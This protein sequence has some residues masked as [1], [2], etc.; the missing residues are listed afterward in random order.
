M[1]AVFDGPVATVCGKD[2]LRIGLLRALAG[3]AICVFRGLFTGFLFCNLSLD[4]ECL[5]NVGKVEVVVEFCCGPDFRGIAIDEVRIF[6]VFKVQGDI[7]KNSGLVVF[8]GEVVIGVALFD[9]IVCNV[10]LG[11]E[12][13]GGNGFS[14]DID[15]IEQRDGGLGF[16]GALDGFICCLDG[17]YFFWV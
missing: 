8:D 13:I 7:F 15:G 5:P 10:F 1:T 4:D 3:D 11:Q 6:P 17:A 14:F 9:Q 12:G 16:V 2:F